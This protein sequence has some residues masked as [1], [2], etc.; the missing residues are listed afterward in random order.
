MS[1]LISYACGLILAGAI[2][3]GVGQ[4]V[5]YHYVFKHADKTAHERFEKDPAGW[6]APKAQIDAHYKEADELV[7]MLSILGALV[8]GFFGGVF[9]CKLFEWN[10][11]KMQKPPGSK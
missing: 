11:S 3:V 6:T 2:W 8:S 1:K 7:S 10:Q 9:G 4:S 5:I